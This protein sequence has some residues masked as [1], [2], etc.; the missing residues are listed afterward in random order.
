GKILYKRS[1]KPLNDGSYK[2]DLIPWSI[3]LFKM[4]TDNWKSVYE[5]IPKYD[6]FCCFPSHLEYRRDIDGYYNKYEPLG[7]LPEYGD[8]NSIINLIKHVFG[9]QY[10]LGLDYLTIIYRYPRQILPILCIVSVLTN[11][12]KT[13][14]LNFLKSIYGDNM[15]ILSN[16]DFSSNFNSNW[17]TGKV[18]VGMEEI[19]L[20]DPKDSE[21]IKN[22]STAKYFNMEAKGMDKVE[23]EFF[24][25]F[26]LASN[27]EDDLIYI[28]P[29]ETRFWV[30][31][32]NVIV[33]RD[34]DYLDKLEKEIPAFLYLLKNR[35]ISCPKK[36]RMWF[37]PEQ[38]ET[39]QLRKIKAHFGDPIKYEI[40]EIV[41]EI[42][43]TMDIDELR[44]TNSDMMKLL[45]VNGIKIRR[46][47]LKKVLEI[48]LKLNHVGNSLL[49]ETYTMDQ[50]GIPYKVEKK[51]KYYSIGSSK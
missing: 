3:N 7:Y 47:Q 10:D 4:E 11:T 48:D 13:T 50:N 38:I 30:R 39:E 51:G 21:K 19:H 20:T 27:H 41:E 22:A 29:N 36:T 44:F 15:S 23:V 32:L 14:F 5:Q 43:Q 28:A 6:N 35:E 17:A 40:L 24:G 18:I 31:K 25:K 9:E 1:K 16:E 33:E 12:S 46:M 34:P 26:I 45:R 49:Y 2:I 42:S 8:C 37:T